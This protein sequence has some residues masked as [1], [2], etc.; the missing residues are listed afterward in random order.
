MGAEKK[1]KNNKNWWDQ[2]GF[3]DEFTFGAMT[4]TT[5]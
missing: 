2:V 1:T 3:D 5:I 4:K